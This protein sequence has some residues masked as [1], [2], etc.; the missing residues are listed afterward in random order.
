MSRA[1][2]H[3]FRRFEAR[4]KITSK[5][6]LWLTVI[7]L[8]LLYIYLQVSIPFLESDTLGILMNRNYLQQKESHV[9]FIVV[10]ALYSLVKHN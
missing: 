10:V 9:T 7:L 3:R 5:S 2:K 4:R 1:D 8:P 6:R